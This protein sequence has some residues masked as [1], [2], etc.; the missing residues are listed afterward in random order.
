VLRADQ[1]SLAAIADGGVV[2]RRDV[3]A[4]DCDEPMTKSNEDTVDPVTNDDSLSEASHESLDP[5]P[6]RVPADH[7]PTRKRKPSMKRKAKTD[8]A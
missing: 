5:V 1:I 6:D 4:I 2:G 7:K 8:A 3:R